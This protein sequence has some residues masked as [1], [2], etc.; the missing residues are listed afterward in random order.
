[1]NNASDGGTAVTALLWSTI[2]GSTFAVWVVLTAAAAFLTVLVSV[3]LGARLVLHAS[4][5][6]Q[7][8]AVLAVLFLPFAMGSSVW[9]YAVTRMAAW[10][11]VQDYLVGADSTTRAIALLF[12]CM[13][14]AI[15]LGVFFCATTLH[16]Y[17]AT[18]RPYFRSHA[19]SVPFFMLCALNRL[20]ASISVLLGLFGAAMM[21]TEAALPTFLYRANP[22]TAPETPNILLARQFREVYASAGA[23]ALPQVALLGLLIALVLY[24]AAWGGTWGAALTLRRVRASL[25]RRHG[26]AGA[27]PAKWPALLWAG[28]AACLLPGVAALIALLMPAPLADDASLGG[29]RLGR[30]AGYRDISAIGMLVGTIL[31][32]SAMAIA[33]RLRYGK[34]DLLRWVE[35]RGAIAGLLFLP[36]FIPVLSLMAALGTF[37][38]G[39]TIGVAGFAAMIVSHFCLHYPI[40]QFICMSLIAAIPERHVAWQRAMR[41][42]YWFS[43]LSDGFR[44]NVAVLVGLFGMGTVLVVTD[45][46]IARWFSHLVRAPEEVLFAALF[47]RLSNA[48]AAMTVAWSVGL[49]ALAVCTTLATAFIHELRKRPDHG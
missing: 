41:L 34:R 21:S 4:P 31:T 33:V 25:A 5:S 47:G 35:T 45:G 7:Y 18:I 28:L 39:G 43:L 32:A 46:S 49:I 42:G 38:H 36:A 37:A 16:R 19:L 26:G 24:G 2:D 9:A 44:R 48:S 6:W 13:A 10:S 3:L 40:F 17:T 14:R 27:A 23:H 30:I 8:G 15:P 11:G 29:T 22:G 1:M 20:P 12:A